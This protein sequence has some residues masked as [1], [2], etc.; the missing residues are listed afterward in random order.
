LAETPADA[1]EARFIGLMSELFQLREAEELDFG[2][3]NSIG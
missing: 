3:F 2:V 1:P